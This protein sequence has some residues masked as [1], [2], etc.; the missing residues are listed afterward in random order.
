MAITQRTK[1][2]YSMK[3]NGGVVIV[4]DKEQD[5]FQGFNGRWLWKIKWGCQWRIVMEDKVRDV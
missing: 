5:T 3:D 1:W 2:T 4:E